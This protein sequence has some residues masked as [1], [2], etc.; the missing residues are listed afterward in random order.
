MKSL[1]LH[2]FR[3]DLRQTWILWALWLLFTL[4][5]FGLA[6]W[7]VAPSNVI[8]QSS[9][10]QLLG[11]I[12]LIHGLILFV[13]IPALILQE[14]TVGVSAFWLTRPIP[15][16]TVLGSKLLALLILVLLP[17]LGQC[18]VLLA[19]GVVLGDV[20]LAG[21]QIGLHQLSWIAVI[22]MLAALSSNFT[23]YLI[24]AVVL[25]ALQFAVD[26]VYTIVFTLKAIRQ[27]GNF[28][29]SAP[30]LGVSRAVASDLLRII[31][32]LGVIFFQY[33]TRRTKQ[34]IALAVLSVLVP[35]FAARYWPWDFLSGPAHTPPTISTAASKIELSIGDPIFCN[36]MPDF[37]GGKPKKTFQANIKCKNGDLSKAISIT[38]LSAEV[39]FPDG[40]KVTSLPLAQ[41][42]IKLFIPG[43][44]IMG[45]SL[46]AALGYMPMMNGNSYNFANGIGQQVFIM[47]KEDFD[48]YKGQTG[49]LTI[50]ANVQLSNYRVVSEWPLQK[51]A[52]V[53]KG[54]KK[55][56]ISEIL[57]K[58]DGLKV[59]M[60][61]REVQL[62][63]RPSTSMQGMMDNGSI[64]ALVSTKK[65]EV[66]MAV[67]GQQ[68]FGNIMNLFMN[69]PMISSLFRGGPGGD[70]IENISSKSLSFGIRDV[71]YGHMPPLP[72]AVT[73]EWLDGAKLLQLEPVP[74]GQLETT[75]TME[76]FKVTGDNNTFRAYNRGKE[77]RELPE[78]L[79]G[80]QLPENPSRSDVWKYILRIVGT[81]G[82]DSMGD[83]DPEITL[84]TK[85]GPANADLLFM[86][87]YNQSRSHYYLI[88][89]I[90]KMDLSGTPFKGMLLRML[91]ANEGLINSVI[92][93]HW[94]A[95]AKGILVEKI[96]WGNE[97]GNFFYEKWIKALASLHDPST[98]PLLL[99]YTKNHLKRNN[100]DHPLDDIRELPGRLISTM[101]GEIWQ[102]YRGKKNEGDFIGTAASWGVTS[103]LERAAEILNTP[104]NGSKE[105]Q[106]LRN[107]AKDAIR[108]TTACPDQLLDTELAAWYTANTSSL[109]FDPHLG[110]FLLHARP[111]VDQEAPWP[112]PSYYM[113]KLGELA[114]KGETSAI[115][116]IADALSRLVEGL[117]PAKDGQRINQ[118]RSLGN[119]AFNVLR[120]AAVKD[121]VV[122]KVLEYA[123][124]KDHFNEGFVPGA[125]SAAAAD[126]N[127]TALDAL[128]HYKDHNWSLLSAIGGLRGAVS[129][130]NPQA[131]DFVLALYADP[132]TSTL[133][134]AKA[135]QRVLTDAIKDAANAGNE[136]AVAIYKEIQQKGK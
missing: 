64:Y 99:S 73:D 116:D 59:D 36:E 27:T 10:S 101:V 39:T 122:F 133:P 20:F 57:Q 9:Y 7:N 89:A 52:I 56:T 24:A 130:N 136:K 35:F 16:G 13:L 37:T 118:L 110:R 115:D 131:V 86:A 21:L 79:K 28:L 85:V 47:S 45:Q 107:R 82:K 98:Y 63:L 81:E 4:A 8:G 102:E 70:K 74:T 2:Q 15:R 109:T 54:S 119:N 69:N 50:R 18:T 76:N 117:D 114:A 17:V 49:K 112:T 55:E 95:D 68:I 129:K 125:Y 33:R 108:N 61:K 3:K 96:A 23:K 14:P 105:Q 88:E 62:Q 128:I 83:N 26:W 123:N 113:K 124:G 132:T 75:L 11:M 58:S 134:E 90:N 67:Q 120:D 72:I 97:T 1:F 19:H 46:D 60:E 41:T 6:A 92:K 94:E 104:S 66:I 84:L 31:L 77:E 51:G 80:L 34:A 30:G 91:P 53:R 43:Q 25:Y 29:P 111:S 135:V 22:M 12:P 65:G 42:L 103:A 5:Q 106:S 121:P 44:A 126:G 78:D 40:K 87:L 32:S 71:D 93:N 127:Q 48:R 38:P 100:Y